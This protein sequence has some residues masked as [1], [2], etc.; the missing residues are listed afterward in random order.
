MN[1]HGQK[2]C[3]IDR[4]PNDVYASPHFKWAELLKSAGRPK[5]AAAARRKYPNGKWPSFLDPELWKNNRR[6][7]YRDAEKMASSMYPRLIKRSLAE[8]MVDH[9]T[10]LIEPLRADLDRP[11]IILSAWRTPAMNVSGGQARASGHI[12]CVATDIKANRKERREIKAWLIDRWRASGDIGYVGF[13]SWG[14][15]IGSPRWDGDVPRRLGI[16]L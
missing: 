4:Y 15:H 7:K 2:G 16:R 14:V 11:L 1:E 9:L 13:Y 5:Q 12:M 3:C 10:R 6:Y 8:N